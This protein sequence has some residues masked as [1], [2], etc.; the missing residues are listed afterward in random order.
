ML[1]VTD[2][3]PILQSSIGPAIL[4]SALGLLLLTMT[5]RISHVV[6]RVRALNTIPHQNNTD[7][8]K[9]EIQILW[10][11]ARLLRLAILCA[12][13][14]A[15]CSAMLIVTIFMFTLIKINMVWPL[16]VLFTLSMTF[17]M[18]SVVMFIFDVEQSLFALQVDIENIVKD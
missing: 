16:A 3:L 2:F 10:K 6:D 5:N 11:R 18:A 1:S 15:F 12:S 4:I 8:I 9:E 7:Q 14:S 17:F 13:S